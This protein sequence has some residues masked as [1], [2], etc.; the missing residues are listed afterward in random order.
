[1]QAN[2]NDID[3]LANTLRTETDAIESII[4]SAHPQYHEK[5][6]GNRK[7]AEAIGAAESDQGEEEDRSLTR[8]ERKYDDS[9]QE[10]K[11]R[12]L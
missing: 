1:M 3:G 2:R 8:E 5:H 6:G 4:A 7:L 12:G 9:I 11:D 10:W